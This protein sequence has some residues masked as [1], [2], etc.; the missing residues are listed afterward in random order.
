MWK[1]DPEKR[2]GHFHV[3]TLIVLIQ[4]VGP[5]HRLINKKSYIINNIQM[6]LL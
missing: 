5:S 2:D 1:V 3:G 6:Q 4:N